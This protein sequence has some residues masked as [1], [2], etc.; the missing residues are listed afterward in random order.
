MK[1]EK[2]IQPPIVKEIWHMIKASQKQHKKWEKQHKIDQQKDREKW[3]KW[4]KKHEADL[5]KQDEEHKKW[6][7]KQAKN[8]RKWE[9]REKKQAEEERKFNKERKK[10]DKFIGDNDNKWGR[11]TE[12]LVTGNLLKRLKQ[13]GF[14]VT[15]TQQRVCD[16]G[17]NQEYDVVI[18]NG[19]EVI[20]VEA[21]TNLKPRHVYK[22]IKDLEKF[23]TFFP[24][25]KNKKLY[26]GMAFL[27]DATAK[28]LGEARKARLFIISA[29]GDVHIQN[30]RSFKPKAY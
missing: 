4:E 30:P 2:Y 13:R 20:V 25:H 3:A 14:K 29:T 5:K 28:A 1:K 18:T 9:K 23:K 21:K 27:M 24:E 19:K 10:L 11:L 26:G 15:K 16:E 17:L 8:E 7:E 22:F 6:K 12:N